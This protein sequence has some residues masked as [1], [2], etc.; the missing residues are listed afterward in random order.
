MKKGLI[1]L[2]ATIVAM[3]AVLG[4]CSSQKKAGVQ[5]VGGMLPENMQKR[6]ENTVATYTD[7]DTF[8]ASGTVTIGGK[9]P[10]SSAMQIT[11]V[12]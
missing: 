5:T 1:A 8:K 6:F 4:S 9:S 11:M 7:W 12:R 3:A 10:F 2:A